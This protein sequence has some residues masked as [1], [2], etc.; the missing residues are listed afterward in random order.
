MSAMKN[1]NLIIQEAS[2]D[3]NS[4]PL[5][6]WIVRK[7]LDGRVPFSELPTSIQEILSQTARGQKEIEYEKKQ[8]KFEFDAGI[9][10]MSQQGDN[11][12]A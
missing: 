1:L 11:N 7:Y 3:L 10:D 4:E 9:V 12:V 5:A 2:A 8:L 6:Q